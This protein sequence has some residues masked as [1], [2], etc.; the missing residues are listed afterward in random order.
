MKYYR[1][2]VD[3]RRQNVEIF[4]F[5]DIAMGGCSNSANKVFRLSNRPRIT[6]VSLL[7]RGAT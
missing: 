1:N 5:G 2:E 6:D 7:I 4:D 3:E